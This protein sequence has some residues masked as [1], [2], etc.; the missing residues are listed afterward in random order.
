VSIGAIPSLPATRK[1]RGWSE[2]V[3]LTLLAALVSACGSSAAPSKSFTGTWNGEWYNSRSG[4]PYTLTL[5]EG[6][7]GEL[8]GVMRIDGTHSSL[9]VDGAISGNLVTIRLPDGTVM[10]GSYRNGKITG[11]FSQDGTRWNFRFVRQAK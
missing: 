7:K 2:L 5:R 10:K 6:P 4:I 8:Q 3:V 11:A 1:Q 9:K